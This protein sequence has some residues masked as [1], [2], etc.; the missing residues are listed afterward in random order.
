MLAGDSEV[1]M[2]CP[3]TRSISELFKGVFGLSTDVKLAVHFSLASCT[4]LAFSITLRPCQAIASVGTGYYLIITMRAMSLTAHV[5]SFLCLL[6]MLEFL[7]IVVGDKPVHQ[8][9]GL[10]LL[11]IT[12]EKFASKTERIA[13]GVK[14]LLAPRA[15]FGANNS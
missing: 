2:V 8:G 15:G 12:A 4:T 9:T 5:I 1:L 10:G 7:P 6:R 13:S 14:Y 11:G 3:G